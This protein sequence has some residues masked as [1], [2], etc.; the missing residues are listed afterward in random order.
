[1]HSAETFILRAAAAL[2]TAVA[3][4]FLGSE[5]LAFI[6]RT[7]S[8]DLGNMG[9]MCI[10]GATLGAAAYVWQYTARWVKAPPAAPE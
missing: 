3:M 4:I 6:Y 2:A 5:L 1:M 9:V 8:F 7:F 10:I